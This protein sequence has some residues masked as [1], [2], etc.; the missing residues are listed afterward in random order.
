MV[1]GLLGSHKKLNY[2][3]TCQVKAY[4]LCQAQNV[5]CT[6]YLKYCRHLCSQ[7][8]NCFNL[9]DFLFWESSWECLDIWAAQRKE[10]QA[11]ATDQFLAVGTTTPAKPKQLNFHKDPVITQNITAFIVPQRP[12]WTVM[13]LINHV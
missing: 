8:A 3:I 12:E 9:W 1:S 13:G 10:R 5:L 6:L 4:L 11:Q 2:P 7:S